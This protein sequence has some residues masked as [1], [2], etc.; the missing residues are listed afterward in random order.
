MDI[1]LQNNLKETKKIINNLIKQTNWSNNN[2]NIDSINDLN[3]ND[4]LWVF[5]IEDDKKCPKYS[6]VFC[7]RCGNYL[8][9]NSLGVS[10]ILCKCKYV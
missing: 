2:E 7:K 9:L 10:I 3:T 1:K 5:W 8:L 4:K 6:C